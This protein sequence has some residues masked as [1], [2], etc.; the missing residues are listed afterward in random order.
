MKKTRISVAVLCIVLIAASVMVCSCKPK[1]EG[2]VLGTGKTSFTIEIIDLEGKTKTY[3]VKTDE[4][5]LEDVLVKV[6][7]TTETGY[8]KTIDGIT[9]DWDVDETWWSISVN[10]EMAETGASEIMVEKDAKYTFKVM[11]GF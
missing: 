5:T 6:G 4:K 10:G 11:Q 8:I 1:E 2:N 9:A 7:L 3:T